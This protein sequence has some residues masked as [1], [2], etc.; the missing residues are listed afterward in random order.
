[1]SIPGANKKI[2]AK[3]NAATSAYLKNFLQL[4]VPA[5]EQQ[6]SDFINL[7]IDLMRTGFDFQRWYDQITFTAVGWVWLKNATGRTWVV[8]QIFGILSSG[9]YTVGQLAVSQH[10][11]LTKSCRLHVQSGATTLNCYLDEMPMLWYVPPGWY[12]GFYC[13][14][15]TTTGT[16]DVTFH[17]W[18]M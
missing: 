1:M 5:K 17:G 4:S 15:H 8:H 9:T 12:V 6:L 7:G 10:A 13:D 16:F 2:I 11:D 3:V 18:L 14:A